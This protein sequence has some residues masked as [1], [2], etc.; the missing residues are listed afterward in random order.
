MRRYL[1]FIVAVLANTLVAL[2][3]GHS[4]NVAAVNNQLVV[5]GGIAGAANGFASQMFVETD[6]SGDPQDFATF[7]NYGP[8]IYWIVPGFSISGL[9]ENS[10]LYLQ[11]L[12]RPVAGTMPPAS[13]VDWYW[14]PDSSAV[15]KVE[16]A[17]DGS[18]LQ[19]RQSAIVNTLLT[20]ATT[21]APPAIKIA[22]PLAADMHSD[23]HDLLKYLMPN[24]LPAEGA[25]GFFAR[26]TSDVYGPSNPFLVII[27]NGGLDGTQML[28]AAAAI[29]RDALLAGDYNHDDKV[30]MADYVLWR[31]T[32][33]STSL[34]AA[35]GSGNA[36]VD[37]ADYDV[38]RSNFGLTFPAG[39]S[40]LGSANVPEPTAP[41]LMTI[42]SL[43]YC[44]VR[45][46]RRPQGLTLLNAA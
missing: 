27:N 37:A 24:P 31:N 9:A 16:V 7:T 19:I 12:A 32:Q 30:D 44:L 4:I 2:G 13:R 8:A 14:D 10:G 34:L 5:S 35:D 38:W 39:G 20:P 1:Y 3:H 43:G 23:N 6:S 11:T 28:T 26:L 42:A 46:R 25:Y 33:N 18:S 22:A 45:S 29:N 36:V 17:P 21:A 15:D 40:G 41:D